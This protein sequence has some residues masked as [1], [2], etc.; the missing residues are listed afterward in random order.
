MC[1]TYNN[2]NPVKANFRKHHEKNAKNLKDMANSLTFTSI[3]NSYLQ[4]N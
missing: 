2:I 4:T 3:D 1:R